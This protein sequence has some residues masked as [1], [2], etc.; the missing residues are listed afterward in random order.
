M[1]LRVIYTAL[2]LCLLTNLAVYSQQNQIELVIEQLGDNEAYDIKGGTECHPGDIIVTVKSDLPNLKFDSNI[3]DIKSV[4]YDALKKEYVFC[5]SKESF[6]LTIGSTNYVSKKT[7]IDGTRNKYAYKVSVQAAVGKVYFKTVPNNALADFG[8]SGQ[9]PQLTTVPIAINSGEYKVRISKYGY[10]PIDTFVVVPSD[11]NIRQ[12]DLMLKPDFA[13]LQLDISAEDNSIFQIFPK[14]EIDT[15]TVSLSYLVNNPNA[16]SYDDAAN[17][18]YFKLYSGGTVPLPSGNYPVTIS[19]PGF[20]TYTT[21]IVATKGAVTPLVVKL[22]PIT[23]YL[24]VTDQENAMNAKLYLDDEP[25]GTIPLYKYKIKVGMHRLRVEK[26]GYISS[27]REYPV[28]SEEGKEIDLPMQM[29]IF[30]RYRIESI[31]T[32]SEVVI[33]GTRRGFTPLDVSLNK[34]EHQ[35]E[36]KRNK[37]LTYVKNVT[38]DSDRTLDTGTINSIMEQNTPFTIK[39]ERKGLEIVIKRDDQIVINNTLTPSEVMLPVGKYKMKLYEN[40]KVRFSGTLHHKGDETINV[41]CYSSGT[42][43]ALAGD[44]FFAKPDV[45]TLDKDY[46]PYHLLGIGQFGRFNIAKGLS[47]AILKASI[48]GVNETYKETDID[49]GYGEGVATNDDNTKYPQYMFAATP[50][51]LNWEFRTGVSIL[52]Q[53]DVAAL[54]SYAYYPQ[55]IKY[56]PFNHVSGQQM[57]FGIEISSRISVLNA[58]IKIGK[59]ILTGGKYNFLVVPSEDFSLEDHTD[60]YNVVE[61]K[62][63]QFIVSVGFTLGDKVSRSNNMLRIKKKPIFT[64][65]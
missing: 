14:V 4:S 29:T 38:I 22:Q 54:G 42:F 2:L 27:E 53:L 63:S 39:S 44:I 5:H 36:I 20:R 24:T 12:L 31:P 32:G 16:R 55:L 9:S 25:I 65:Y 1:N 52:K 8:F 10:I 46:T 35:I 15:A 48:F 61:T 18:K 60:K 50:L 43:T 62:M 7:Y 6:W 51:F 30:K 23:G 28:L 45:T 11:G 13:K 40:N 57:F 47:T 49:T 34:G 3:M 33:D 64:N 21:R 59:Q 37:Y 26:E 56:I 17:L 19:A 41:P 58:N